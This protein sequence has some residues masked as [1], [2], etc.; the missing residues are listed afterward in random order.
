MARML[1][2]APLAH[3]QTLANPRNSEF[4]V[5][6]CAVQ[7]SDHQVDNAQVEALLLRVGEGDPLLFLL[8]L[9]HQLLRL[10]VLAGHDVSDAKVRQHN[11]GSFEYVVFVFFHCAERRRC[12]NKFRINNV[13]SSK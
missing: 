13:S 10:L 1:V 6:F 3:L 12:E 9:L 7:C 2:F 5:S 4:E 11:G 8:D